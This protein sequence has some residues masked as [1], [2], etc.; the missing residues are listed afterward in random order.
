MY[1][2]NIQRVLPFCEINQHTKNKNYETLCMLN[3]IIRYT[4]VD[5]H[6]FRKCQVASNVIEIMITII[7]SLLL[8]NVVVGGLRSVLL[9]HS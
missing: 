4:R 2:N 1:N 9:V 3:N 6:K 8:V 5:D 7:L